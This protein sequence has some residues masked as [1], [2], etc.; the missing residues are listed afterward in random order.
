MADRFSGDF[1]PS[2]FIYSAGTTALAVHEDDHMLQSLDMD[3]IVD[4]FR[5]QGE[6]NQGFFEIGCCLSSCPC[7]L[8]PMAQEG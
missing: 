7:T 3:I 1:V 4:L 8:F 5:V 2:G 6:G